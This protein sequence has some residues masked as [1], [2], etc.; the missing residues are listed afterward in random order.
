MISIAGYLGII[1]SCAV[2]EAREFPQNF[3]GSWN[4]NTTF[5]KMPTRDNHLEYHI[6]MMIEIAPNGMITG[7]VGNAEIVPTFM[8]ETPNFVQIFVSGRWRARF[9]I[10]GKLAEGI[11]DD[12]FIDG[13]G[14]CYFIAEN[15]EGLISR[16]DIHTTINGK[17]VW[18][19]MWPFVLERL[20]KTTLSH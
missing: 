8:E 1:M 4:G 19:S 6:N 2:N 7:K 5:L 10:K 3:V 20:R 16:L 9:R 14:W 11:E 18:L 13:D 17:K 15:K 12:A